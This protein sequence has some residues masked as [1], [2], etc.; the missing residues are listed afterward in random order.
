[1]DVTQ[2]RERC[3]IGRHADDRIVSH[4]EEPAQHYNCEE[5][6][7]ATTYSTLK[8]EPTSNAW[9]HLQRDTRE[10]WRYPAFRGCRQA[11]D[12]ETPFSTTSTLSAMCRR[13]P[14]ELHQQCQP[15]TL[16]TQRR[17][18]PANCDGCS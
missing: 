11:E 4:R 14:S 18:A 15:V 10:L 7:R 13:R 5:W 2:W 3:E 6:R 8:L 16:G 1:M 9:E 17:A 12:K